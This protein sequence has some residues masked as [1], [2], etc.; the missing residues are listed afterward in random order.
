MLDNNLHTVWDAYHI[1]YTYIHTDKES[2]FTI[3]HC[4]V[5]SMIYDIC[6][7]GEVHHQYSYGIFHSP[8]YMCI[9]VDNIHVSV[10]HDEVFNPKLA[11]YKANQNDINIYKQKIAE[12]VSI[13]SVLACIQNCSDKCCHSVSHRVD[14]SQHYD[15]LVDIMVSAS[16][17]I[18]HTCKPNENTHLPRWTTM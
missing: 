16:E 8:V 4:L 2:T 15:K 14:V 1:D 9:N 11:W 10:Y 18:S 5:N 6:V 17:H 7:A 3:D 13:L 12:S